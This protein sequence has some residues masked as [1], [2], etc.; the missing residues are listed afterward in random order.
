VSKVPNP[1]EGK[2]VILR[3]T[4][5][6]NE[7]EST[8]CLVYKATKGKLKPLLGIMD[9]PSEVSAGNTRIIKIKV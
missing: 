7:A 6:D 2:I 9:L 4:E 1:L 8:V 5:C 3:Y